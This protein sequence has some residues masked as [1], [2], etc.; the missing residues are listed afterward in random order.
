MATASA[1]REGRFVEV[2][3]TDSGVGLT[4]DFLPYV[5]DRFRQAD[6]SFTRAHGGLGLGLSIVKQVVEMHGGQVSAASDGPGHGSVFTVRLPPG[7]V[8]QV[9]EGVGG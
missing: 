2:T 1:A 3:V 9:D 4:P 5:F 6:Q 8:D 7:A